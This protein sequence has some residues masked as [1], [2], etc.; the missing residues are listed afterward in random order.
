MINFI[1]NFENIQIYI[2]IYYIFKLH[3][4]VNV[5]TN[6]IIIILNDIDQQSAYIELKFNLNI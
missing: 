5:F 1:L 3:S 2:N 4:T 6:I